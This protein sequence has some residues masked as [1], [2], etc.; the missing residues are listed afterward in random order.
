MGPIRQQQQQLSLHSR[1]GAT[2]TMAAMVIAMSGRSENPNTIHA[3]TKCLS[4]KTEENGQK[5]QKRAKSVIKQK[6]GVT[7]PRPWEQKCW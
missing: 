1:V 5:K 6:P 4:A 3:E 2:P 7:P